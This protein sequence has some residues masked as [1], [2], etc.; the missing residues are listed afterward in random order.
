MPAKDISDAIGKLEKLH[1]TQFKQVMEKIPAKLSDVMTVLKK[2]F[3]TQLRNDHEAIR[4][5][6]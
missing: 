1:E 3:L 2:V 4:A 5:N 6:E